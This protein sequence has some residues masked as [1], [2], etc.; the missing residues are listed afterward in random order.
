MMDLISTNLEERRCLPIFN[1]PSDITVS[2][3]HYKASQLDPDIS[4]IAD[5][6][7]MTKSKRKCMAVTS[8]R[9]FMSHLA[10]IALSHF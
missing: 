6:G 8:T 9:N 3:Y 7:E 10:A 5:G 1:I 4:I 2:H